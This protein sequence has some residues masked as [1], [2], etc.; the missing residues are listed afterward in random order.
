MEFSRAKGR[1]PLASL[2]NRLVAHSTRVF[3]L[4]RTLAWCL[5]LAMLSRRRSRE[6]S[7][8]ID[9]AEFVTPR[10]VVEVPDFE[11]G[12]LSAVRMRVGARWW[13]AVDHVREYTAHTLGQ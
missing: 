3:D 9:G 1:W 6:I 5:D 2:G 8:R 11:S 12:A 10:L 4:R 13:S 7:R